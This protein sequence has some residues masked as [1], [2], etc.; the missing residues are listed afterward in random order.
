MPFPAL[1]PTNRDFSPGD[2]PVKSYNAQSGAEVRILYGDTRSSMTLALGYDN[3]ADAQAEQFLTHYDE[4]KGTFGTFTINSATKA[5]W[6]GN[7]NAI[8]TGSINR[9]RYADPPQ[10]TAVRPGRSSVRV[11]LI[12]VF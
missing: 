5:G 6:S 2:Y 12:G 8:D 9:F 10:V 3:I 4:S 11:N 1:R 7:A